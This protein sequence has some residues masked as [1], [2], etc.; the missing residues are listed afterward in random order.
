VRRRTFLAGALAL[1]IG[2]CGLDLDI[3]V[4]GQP[5]RPS[6]I[7]RGGLRLGPHRLYDFI[8]RRF[9]EGAWEQRPELV[10]WA[11]RRKGEG[12]IRAESLAY[13]QAPPDARTAHPAEPLEPGTVYVVTASGPGYAGSRYFAIKDGRLL[14]SRDASRPAR[15]ALTRQLNG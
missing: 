14:V 6:F 9:A 1:P 5:S 4:A 8:V 13:G 7:L 3:D 11:I 12:T 15:L 2:G 10:V